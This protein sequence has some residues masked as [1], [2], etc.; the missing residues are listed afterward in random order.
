M[1]VQAQTTTCN[2]KNFLLSGH[3]ASNNSHKNVINIEFQLDNSDLMLK[4]KL[5]LINEKEINIEKF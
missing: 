4:E 3:I 2:T 5:N 1:I